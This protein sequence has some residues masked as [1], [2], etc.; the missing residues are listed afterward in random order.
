MEM[1]VLNETGV[2][3][4]KE[5]VLPGKNTL[6]YEIPK[7]TKNKIIVPNRE[8]KIEELFNTLRPLGFKMLAEDE[9]GVETEIA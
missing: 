7:I 8:R 6:G 4:G 1:A 3:P 9:N 2:W 5:D